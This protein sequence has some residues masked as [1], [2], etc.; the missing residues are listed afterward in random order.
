MPNIRPFGGR[1]PSIDPAAYVDDSAVVIG[2]VTIG[3]ESSVWPMA[4]VRGDVH[5]IR[6]GRATSVQDGAVLHVSHDSRFVPGGH[7][8][9]L[10]DGITVGHQATLHGCEIGNRCLIGIGARVLDG[11]VLEPH[12][13]LGAGALVPPGK[14]LEGGSLWVGVPARRMR[15]LTTEELDYLTYSAGHY[16]RLAGHYLAA[17]RTY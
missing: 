5:S 3:S 7:P 11:A 2:D 8:L 6:I 1:A 14:H 4:V 17:R 16:V 9:L 10:G 13:L 12:T 15:V